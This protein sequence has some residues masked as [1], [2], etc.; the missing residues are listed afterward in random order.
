MET[1]LSQEPVEGQETLAA[2]VGSRLCHDLVSP[3]GAIG[4]GV[5][6]LQ[7]TLPASEELALIGAAVAA[8]QARL[9]LFRLAFGAAQA[10]QRV[11][12][13]EL[14]GALEA[15]AGGGRI[16]LQTELPEP[17]PRPRAKRLA[18]AALCAESALAWGGGLSLDATGLSARAPRLQIEAPLWDALAAGTPPRTTPARVHFALLAAG[19]PVRVERGAGTLALFP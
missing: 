2:L 1:F 14:A 19:G 11:E 7:M 18:L 12:G 16:A 5:E 9:R 10:E 3:L 13:H 15:L 8:A 17:L 4:N 6:L